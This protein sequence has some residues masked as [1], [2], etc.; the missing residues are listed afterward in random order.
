MS[1]RHS[2]EMLRLWIAGDEPCCEINL[3][4]RAYQ[5]EL[6]GLDEE[7]AWGELLAEAVHEIAYSLGYQYG[8]DYESAIHRILKV[9]ET[10]LSAR[11]S[12]RTDGS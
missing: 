2:V 9:M 6:D 7:V 11:I 1:D 10:D 5:G 3:L 4:Q 8:I 12:R